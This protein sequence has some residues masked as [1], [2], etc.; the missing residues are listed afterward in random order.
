MGCSWCAYPV[1]CEAEPEAAVAVIPSFESSVVVWVQV[2]HI[3]CSCTH[4][5]DCLSHEFPPNLEVKVLSCCVITLCLCH[6]V[7]VLLLSLAAP[8]SRCASILF[9]YVTATYISHPP[10]AAYSG[11]PDTY[12][13][14]ALFHQPTMSCVCAH[15]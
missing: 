4:A 7:C 9:E 13:V 5:L 8:T 14:D 12:S 3:F 2:C 11:I 10:A 6:C 15:P 1:V